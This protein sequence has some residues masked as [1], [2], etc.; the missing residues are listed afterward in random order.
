MR[1]MQTA[2]EPPYAF[3]TEGTAMTAV[4]DADQ[5]S[6]QVYLRLARASSESVEKP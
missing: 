3:F 4:P 2:T 1:G 6:I 5:C